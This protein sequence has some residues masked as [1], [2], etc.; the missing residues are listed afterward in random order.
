MS[1]S[2]QEIAQL[3][4]DAADYMPDTCTIQ[5]PTHTKDAQG[6]WTTAWADTYTS[7]SCRL[8]PLPM[9]QGAEMEGEQV[10]AVSRWV[11]TVAYN[12]AIAENYRV[13]H[14]SETY[15]VV[16]MED[17]HSNRTAKRVYLRRLDAGA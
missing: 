3:R 13:V 15:E 17:T 4:A 16:R 2:T 8:A 6:G 7:I 1:L 5:T 14:D 10:Q 9:Q 12:Q 11:L